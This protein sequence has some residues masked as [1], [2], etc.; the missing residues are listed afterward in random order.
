MMTTV[1][2]PVATVISPVVTVSPAPVNALP[3][4]PLVQ[5]VD[6]LFTTK[7]IN[8]YSSSNLKLTLQVK[9]DGTGSLLLLDTIT[10]LS[11]D[12]LIPK[13]KVSDGLNVFELI[14][15]NTARIIAEGVRA[16]NAEHVLDTRV[17]T[18]TIQ[19]QSERDIILSKI[20][21]LVASVDAVNLLYKGVTD[22]DRLTVTNF[23]SLINSQMSGEIA[24]AIQR[25][26]QI[27]LSVNVESVRANLSEANIRSELETLSNRQIADD[28][29][30]RS[31]LSVESTRA[32]AAELVL[33]TSVTKTNTDLLTEVNRAM[34]YENLLNSL[35]TCAILKADTEKV[36]AL[37]AEQVL[38][39]KFLSILS[40]VDA[41]ALNSLA[42]IV[43]NFSSV[44]AGH[45]TRLSN[46]EKY[47]K[48]TF[49]LESIGPLLLT[50][51]IQLV[52]SL[53][54]S[55]KYVPDETAPTA[56]PYG[57]AFNNT[58]QKQ[59]FN[60]YMFSQT[61]DQH[62]VTFGNLTGLY[63]R[64]KMNT[65]TGLQSFPFITVY[66]KKTATGNAG[67]WY[68]SRTTYTIK[69]SHTVVVG[70]DVLLYIGNDIPSIFTD[71][72]HSQLEKSF[73][74]NGSPQAVDEILT[75][76]IASD[77]SAVIGAVDV[78]IENLVLEIMN[79]H[80]NIDFN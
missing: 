56:S 6:L 21:D 9:S 58:L 14:S 5:P 24:R 3:S 51:M 45:T 29:L 57:W 62:D 18:E 15:A 72:K 40:N 25:E 28:A 67:S 2:S 76:A 47:M 71:S 30:V 66:T 41:T 73:S 69:S 35:A 68:N 23:A 39:D 12:I 61:V 16:V 17:V 4:I 34:S 48:S 50:D 78:V 32:V 65:I 10:N 77:S 43:A 79:V 63:L 74:S 33:Q 36:R 27:A 31:S 37:A 54:D 75:I 42:E 70:D 44:D 52:V 8:L 59:K 20:V 80:T 64:V 22:S 13:L 60:W 46:I 1:I 53:A 49:G 11:K 26:D 38:T 7:S 19:R 55:A